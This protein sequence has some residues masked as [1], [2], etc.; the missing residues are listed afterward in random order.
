[1]C[2][3]PT[4]N[5]APHPT[6]GHFGKSFNMVDDLRPITNGWI[7]RMLLEAYNAKINKLPN[8]ATRAFEGTVDVELPEGHE[9]LDWKFKQ[10]HS[11]GVV[12]SKAGVKGTSLLAYRGDKKGIRVEARK[13]A[14]T[15]FVAVGLGLIRTEGFPGSSSD[16]QQLRK[17]S[18]LR[19][20][21]S[22]KAL[23]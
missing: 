17:G 9:L 8:G 13:Y 7:N 1:M 5:P 11:S 20:Q 21:L 4:P 16:K 14:E 19:S 22:H 2:A 12:I 18:K 15:V 6:L 10:L 3:D 23:R